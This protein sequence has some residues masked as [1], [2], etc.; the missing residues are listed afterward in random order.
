[1]LTINS[2]SIKQR[3]NE[4]L[5]DKFSEAT[6]DQDDTEELNNDDVAESLDE[7][8]RFKIVRVRIRNGKIQRRKKISTVKGWTFRGGRFT[9]MSATE[10]R[11]RRMGARKAKIKRRAEKSRIRLHMKRSLRKRH[12]LG[13]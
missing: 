7:A 12:A 13:L 4:A 10:R 5:R 6:I 2:D 1:M 3:L 11:H 9:R 8:G